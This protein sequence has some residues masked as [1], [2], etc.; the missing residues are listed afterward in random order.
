MRIEHT[1]AGSEVARIGIEGLERPLWLLHLTDS[2]M[3]EGDERDPEAVDDVERFRARFQERT[4]GGVSTVDLFRQTL[5]EA[6]NRGVDAAVLTGDIVHFPAWAGLDIVRDGLR[7]L[8][9]PSL[10]TSGNHDWHFPFTE[11]CESTRAA[12]YPRFRELAG[13]DPSCGSVQVGGVRLISLDD[14]TYQLSLAQVEFLRTELAR[15]EPSLLFVHIPFVVDTLLPPVIDKWGSPIVVG[16]TEGWTQEARERWKVGEIAE[17][18]QACLDLLRSPVAENLAGIFCGHVH[19]AHDD[20]IRPGCRQYVG[21]PGF[22]AGRRWIELAP[23][24]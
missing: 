1:P 4:P 16:A 13:E 8:G 23:L 18:T 9:V 10:F 11:W 19:F 22:E 17:G 2:H 21:A 5:A 14:S 12:Q 6:G 24:A 7:D 15:G 3:A 20:E